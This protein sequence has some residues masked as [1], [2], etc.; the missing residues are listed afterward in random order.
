MG[1]IRMFL[2]NL[3]LPIAAA[4]KI[5]PSETYA[6]AAVR[7]ANMKLDKVNQ[8]N[9]KKIKEYR[10]AA[11]KY[12]NEALKLLTLCGGNPNKLTP[13]QKQLLLS[14]LQRH[15]MEQQNIL[16]V[17]SCDKRSYRLSSEARKAQ[18]MNESSKMTEDAM[19]QYKAAGLLDTE[20]MAKQLRKTN[21]FHR[22][23]V[24]VSEVRRDLN[25][26]EEADDPKEEVEF[27]DLSQFSAEIQQLTDQINQKAEHQVYEAFADMPAVNRR[28]AIAASAAAAPAYRYPNNH[29][30]EIQVEADNNEMEDQH[31]EDFARRVNQVLGPNDG[32]AED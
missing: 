2:A 31:N 32:D 10:T 23:L 27:D 7:E 17:S 8:L 29:D 14:A 13:V 28:L 9:E 12:K 24:A 19:K 21:K 15:K 25:D 11:E 22:S 3:G 16:D 30:W 20:T 4:V 1:V 5:D 18:H 26:L 6:S